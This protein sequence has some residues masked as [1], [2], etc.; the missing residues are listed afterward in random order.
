MQRK[1]SILD[2]FEADSKPEPKAIHSKTYHE[3]NSLTSLYFEN[4]P[5]KT[6]KTISKLINDTDSL[7]HSVGTSSVEYSETP[8]SGY[9]GALKHMGRDITNL[10]Q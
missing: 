2:I 10:Q 4:N 8:Y 6:N 3:V 1:V 9:S 5:W 7:V